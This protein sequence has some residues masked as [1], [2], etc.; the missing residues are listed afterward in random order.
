MW[1][2]VGIVVG[3]LILIFILKAL[4]SSS[5]ISHFDSGKVRCPH[6][7][8]YVKPPRSQYDDFP[9]GTGRSFTYN[10]DWTCPKCGNTIYSSRTIS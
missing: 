9:G 3:M 10:V 4:F 5:S 7:Y 8:E 2:I 6:Y 1:L